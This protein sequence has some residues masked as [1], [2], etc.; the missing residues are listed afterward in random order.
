MNTG[1][2]L[3]GRIGNDA[4][5]DGICC[6]C[7]DSDGSEHLEDGAEDHG[8]PIADGSRGDTGRPGVGHIVYQT[9]NIRVS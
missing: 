9:V 2:A 6:S 8:L 1:V 5:L 4:V 3:E 7:S